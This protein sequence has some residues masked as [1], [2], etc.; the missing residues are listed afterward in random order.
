MAARQHPNAAAHAA[1]LFVEHVLLPLGKDA[2]PTISL[3]SPINHE[4]DTEPLIEA[5]HH[6]HLTLALPVTA[7][8]KRPLIFRSYAPGDG[9]C[10]GFFGEMIPRKEAREVR[11]D[12][13]VAPLLAFTREG[14][15]LGYGGG[16]YDRTLA[17]MRQSGPVLAVG[18]AYGI[19]EVDAIP[20]SH[21][22]QP[23]DWVVTE[24]QAIRC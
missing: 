7:G 23:L 19:Q 9:L 24:R 8:K 1:R 20:L 3:Y 21:V 13:V 4:L 22:D 14:G 16:F 2:N 6:R 12:I 18:F 15:R 11:P 17:Q 10:K 5:L